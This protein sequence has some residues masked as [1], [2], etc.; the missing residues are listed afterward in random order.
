MSPTPFAPNYQHDARYALV[1]GNP[2]EEM[3]AAM[4]SLG[5]STDGAEGYKDKFGVTLKPSLTAIQ[6]AGAHLLVASSNASSIVTAQL[7]SSSAENDA[8]SMSGSNWLKGILLGAAL[9]T[10]SV[11]TAR[12]TPYYALGVCV[13]ANSMTVGTDAPGTEIDPIS[14]ANSYIVKYQNQSNSP[15]RWY[16]A[17]QSTFYNATINTMAAPKHGTLILNPNAGI[18][19]SASEEGWYYYVSNKGSSGEDTFVVQVEKYGLKINIHYTIEIP[20]L[21]ERPYDEKW[22]P[23]GFCEQETWKISQIDVIGA[24]GTTLI[25]T[26]VTPD[27]SFLPTSPSTYQANVTLNLPNA[28]IG[29]SNLAGA[30]VGQEST[31]GSTTIITLDTN[32]GGYGWFLDP[33]PAD[34]SEFLPTSNTNEWIA[35]AGSAADG[36]MDMLSESQR[37]QRLRFPHEFPRSIRS[38]SVV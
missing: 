20:S 21:D 10:T 28:D 2:F 19:I 37:G 7:L 13:I 25:S 27:N 4:A 29:I 38:L 22:N 11:A 9:S 17:D 5:L 35:K 30:A 12:T 14:A 8:M 15:L 36:K 33:T 24:D 26:T 32:A 6:G 34:N 31:S 18:N 1:G 3:R 23:D 16:V